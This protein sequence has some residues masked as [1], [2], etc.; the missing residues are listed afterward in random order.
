MARF[1]PFYPISDGSSPASASSAPLRSRPC[2]RVRVSWSP[3]S[4]ASH[5]G[6]SASAQLFVLDGAAGI[7]EAP[8]S[9]RPRVRNGDGRS[10]RAFRPPSPA[11]QYKRRLCTRGP[12]RPASPASGGCLMRFYSRLERACASDG[13]K[14]WPGTS[15]RQHLGRGSS[16]QAHSHDRTLTK[17][18]GRTD[19][20]RTE[21]RRPS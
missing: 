21:R 4:S 17:R 15:A 19:R 12:H 14:K 6:R 2:R 9:R 13:R 3:L 7:S 10:H 11:G 20:G 16:W 18:P 8:S 1:R 5:R